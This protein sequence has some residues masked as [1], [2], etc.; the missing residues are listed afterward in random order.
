MIKIIKGVYGY[1]DGKFIKPIT[2][3][4]GPLELSPEKEKRLVDIGVAVYVDA[5]QQTPAAAPAASAA[6]TTPVTPKADNVPPETKTDESDEGLVY[7]MDMTRAELEKVAESYGIDASGAKNKA[8]V[9]NMID[10][11]KAAA[12]AEED[13]VDDGETPPVFGAAD[14]VE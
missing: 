14:P 4:D 1:N 13:V 5:P 12:A 9:I 3:K 7:N 8:E 10:E 2:Q 11:A 6:P